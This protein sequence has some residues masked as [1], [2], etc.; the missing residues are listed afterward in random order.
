MVTKSVAIVGT[1]QIGRR[2]LESLARS[3]M[4]LIVY[5]VEPFSSALIQAKE[6]VQKTTSGCSRLV[7]CQNIHDLPDALDLVIVATTADVRRFAVEE[8]L[9]GR[10]IPFLILEKVVFQDADSF[11]AVQRLIQEKKVQ[12]WVNCPMRLH[13]FF[14]HLKEKMRLASRVTYHASG[15]RL[16]L[17]SNS[18][19]HL[20]LFAYLTK[21]PIEQLFAEDLDPVVH[22]A[23]RPGFVEFTGTLRGRS[24]NGS[25]TITSYDR[26]GTPLTLFLDS[27]I[28]R[29]A[30]HPLEGYVWL[31]DE[32]TG[33]RWE[34]KDY[35]VLL[36]SQL[37]SRIV[38]DI[39]TNGRSD[40]P[41]FEE[42][43]RLHL[44]LLRVLGEHHSQVTK[45]GGSV[46]PI[47]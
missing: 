9:R 31:A 14:R 20:D 44:P 32:R 23:K 5:A 25:I 3:E 15:T 42:S 37:T 30:V 47:T 27:D 16:G 17:G 33:W 10:R 21:H 18:I 38:K 43:L 36:Q 45:K 22:P 28:L 6:I 26:E 39:L 1:G 19:H 40:L 13:P 7:C 34:R 8:L 29:C 24:S 41:T 2:H 11:S 35:P 12:T 46:C 4:Q